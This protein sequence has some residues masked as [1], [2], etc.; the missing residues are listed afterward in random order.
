MPEGTLELTKVPSVRVGMRIRRM[1]ADVFQVI[2]DPY[3]T[4]K[5][6]YTKSSGKMTQEPSWSGNGRCTRSR[7]GSPS[8]K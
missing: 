1:P 4:S 3:I 5:I 7:A 6:W 2:V 8:R